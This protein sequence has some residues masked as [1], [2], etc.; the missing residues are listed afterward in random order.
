MA[1][2]NCHGAESRSVAQDGVQWRDFSILQPPFPRFKRFS[3]LSLPCSWDYRLAPPYSANFFVFLVE[4]GFHYVGQACLKLLTSS[5]LP[6]L[7]SQSAGIT[8]TSYRTQA[9]IWNFALAAQTGVQWWVLGSLQPPPPGFKDFPASA[10]QVAGITG[11]RRHIQLIFCIFSRD[12]VSP[13]L[14]G[15][16]QTPNFRGPTRLG[17]PNAPSPLNFL[18]RVS[19]L[20]K[21][22]VLCC[23]RRAEIDS[24][25]PAELQLTQGFGFKTDMVSLCCPGWSVVA[26]SQLTAASPSQTQA[27]LLQTMFHYIAQAGLKL[28]SSNDPPT[29]ASQSAGIIE[30]RSRFVAQDGLELLYSGSLPALASQSAG[31]T[32]MSH[33]AWP[34]ANLNGL[35][36]NLVLSSGWSAVAPSRLTATSTSQVQVILLPQLPELR[37]PPRPAKFCI[38]NR[39]RV[40]PCWLGW[41]QYRDPVIHPPW[42]PKVLGL[43]MQSHCVT[44]VECGGTILGHC[45]LCLPGSSNSLASAFWCEPLHKPLLSMAEPQL[46]LHHPNSMESLLLSAFYN[47]LTLSPRLECNGMILAHCSLDLL[48][49]TSDSPV[50][51]PQGL[52]LS[53]R[54]ECSG[55]MTVHCNFNLLSSSDP[56]ASAPHSA[57]IPD[58][59]SFLLPRLEH[60]GMVSAHCNLRLPG[61]SDS[62]ASASQTGSHYVTRAGLKLLDPRDPSTSASLRTTV[63]PHVVPELNTHQ[64]TLDVERSCPMQIPSGGDRT[65]VVSLSKASLCLA[66]T[67]LVC[68]PHSSWLPDKNSGSTA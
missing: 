8:D 64:D 15:W 25:S 38:F 14:S 50:S 33:H 48:L 59:I 44:R 68:V 28:L 34:I 40:S 24:P 22:K 46:L 55:S 20:L 61:S 56:S 2:V 41:C 9:P 1:F 11:L 57:G 52:A 3:C 23:G 42:P 51:A 31:I 19:R 63:A 21:P 10:S 65:S 32:V 45:N 49:G 18:F 39:D 27:I 30:T 17:L 16:P 53:P 36:W 58:G 62:P 13:Y 7:A 47:G 26:R 29:S 6:T 37:V 12:R 5:D 54:L 67:P 66:H 4:I 35:I 43:Q 60:S